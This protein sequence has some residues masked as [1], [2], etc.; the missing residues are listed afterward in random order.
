ML[1]QVYRQ[2]KSKLIIY[3]DYFF[4]LNKKLLST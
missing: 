2:I 4:M 3:G 1:M